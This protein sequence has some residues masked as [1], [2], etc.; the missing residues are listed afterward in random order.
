M[1]KRHGFCGGGGF[2]S[3][4]VFGCFS[5]S[6]LSGSSIEGSWRFCYLRLGE[7]F[8]GF[9]P[10]R[11][12]GSGIAGCESLCYLRLREGIRV[13]LTRKSIGKRHGGLLEFLLPAFERKDSDVSH[14]AGIGKRHRF[15]LVRVGDILY[16]DGLDKRFV[17][18]RLNPTEKHR[19]EGGLHEYP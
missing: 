5:S 7:E 9:S 14:K 13:F 12:S 16:N 2:S 17:Y 15:L 4:E 18:E 11:V 3:R 10:R 19:Q 8:R 1:G 6:R